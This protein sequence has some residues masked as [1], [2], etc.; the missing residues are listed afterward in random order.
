MKPWHKEFLELLRKHYTE[1]RKV[2]PN[3]S[4]RA[5]ARDLK[6]SP[7]PTSALIK[8]TQYWDFSPEWALSVLSNIPLKKETE[9]KLRVMMGFTD[10]LP[11][12]HLTEEQTETLFS[13]WYYI[14][15][16]M[17]FDLAPSDEDKVAQI[18][19]RLG[20]TENEAAQAI[21]FLL[22]KKFLT[23]NETGISRNR[24]DVVETSDG[25]TNKVIENFHADHLGL[26]QKALRSLPVERR[27][28]QTLSFAGKASQLEELRQEIRLF[29]EKIAVLMSQETDNDEVY[30]F[31]IQL[32]PMNFETAAPE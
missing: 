32:F 31:S 17:F 8:G 23:K 30:R 2:N 5:L 22:S 25:I 4:L 6:L 15:V 18:S 19:H 28:F 12:V 24:D 21:E 16:L 1:K 9:N 7:G 11:R 3:Y 13:K 14:D 27:E 29:T 20:L 10:S 26:A